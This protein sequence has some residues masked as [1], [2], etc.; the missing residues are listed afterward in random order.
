[1]TLLSVKNISS[2]YSNNTVL[3]N[4][5]FHVED[6]EIVS[7]I[8]PNGAGKSTALKTVF[9][10]LR[11]SE[12]SVV[13]KDK[14]ITNAKPHQ[15]PLMGMSFVHQ[16]RQVFRSMSV[17]DNLVLGAFINKEEENLEKVYSMFP[18][19]K[20]KRKQIASTLS[21]G[22]QQQLAIGRALMLN[23]KLLMLDEPSLGLDPKTVELVFDKIKEIRKNGT[24]ILLAEQNAHMALDI[25]D[26]VYVFE[27]GRIKLTGIGAHLMRNKNIQKLYLGG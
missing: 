5:S 26:R 18:A 15:L 2:G 25:S 7:L 24:T 17:E 8:G 14:D 4:I 16:G 13:F 9:G 21:G 11:V 1:M 22:Q 12:G 23:P 6:G 20:E 27:A 19:L 3:N 10:F